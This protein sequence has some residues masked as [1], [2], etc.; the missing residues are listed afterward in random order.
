MHHRYS[1]FPRYQHHFSQPLHLDAEVHPTAAR[2]ECPKSELPAPHHTPKEFLNFCSWKVVNA[3]LKISRCKIS[4]EEYLLVF[5]LP[6]CSSHTIQDRTPTTVQPSAQAGEP[7]VI[8]LSKS[9]RESKL[10]VCEGLTRFP[11]ATNTYES[12]Q[13]VKGQ[14]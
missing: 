4:F 13:F 5:N 2:C 10:S 7:F 11:T 12:N 3:T 8:L 9:T 1:N 6:F 14:K